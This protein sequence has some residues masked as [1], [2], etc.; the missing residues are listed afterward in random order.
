VIGKNVEGS[1]LQVELESLSFVI[2]TFAVAA[3]S[4]DTLSSVYYEVKNN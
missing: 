2:R 1:A 3:A 4:V